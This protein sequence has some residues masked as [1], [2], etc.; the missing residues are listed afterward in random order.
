[1][2]K[3]GKSIA[4]TVILIFLGSG[5]AMAG[6]AEMEQLKQQIQQLTKSMA[7]L[8]QDKRAEEASGEPEK[9]LSLNGVLGGAYQYQDV[10]G[11]GYIDGGNN[12]IESTQVFETYVNF[13]LS[14]YFA[15]TLD[16]QYMVD[17]YFDSSNDP[18]GWILGIRGVT[19]F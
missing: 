11:D 8:E 4:L 2:K 9:K 7:E 5:I 12:E 18:K 1:M 15:L 3:T 13:G 17:D 10:S 19:E 6:D 16:V 14:E